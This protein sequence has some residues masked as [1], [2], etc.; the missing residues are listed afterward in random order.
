MSMFAYFIINLKKEYMHV[1]NSL[2]KKII[3]IIILYIGLFFVMVTIISKNHD[4]RFMSPA[5]VVLNIVSAVGLYG[6][7]ELIAE[8]IKLDNENKKIFYVLM[9]IV[10]VLSQIFF[11][12]SSGQ[13]SDKI[14]ETGILKFF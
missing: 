9:F 10:I 3:N 5:F 13:L 4:I 1:F 8:K 11:I 14:I 6:I 12:V 7:F 2:P